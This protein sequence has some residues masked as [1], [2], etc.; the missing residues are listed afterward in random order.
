MVLMLVLLEVPKHL[1][2][3]RVLLLKRTLVSCQN[4]P[5]RYTP[6]PVL[7]RHPTLFPA[8]LAFL[9]VFFAAPSTEPP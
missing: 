5:L 8:A 4:S 3:A 9:L 2:C 1:L 7:T 6:G